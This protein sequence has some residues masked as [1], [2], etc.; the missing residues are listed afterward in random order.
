MVKVHS[1]L[2]LPERYVQENKRGMVDEFNKSL[3]KVINDNQ[4]RDGPYFLSYHENDDKKHT[5][6][7]R[8]KWSASYDLPFKW[9]RQIVYWVDNSKGFK[10]WLWTVD[11][12]RKTFFNVEGVEKA[13]KSGAL[14]PRK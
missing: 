1:D 9:A 6:L 2:I 7:I 3:D 11:D 10:E 5:N 14:S 8:A 12:N 13:R 4:Y